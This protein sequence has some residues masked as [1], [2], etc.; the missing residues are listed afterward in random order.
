M[1]KILPQIIDSCRICPYLSELPP[2]DENNE[3]DYNYFKCKQTKEII[4]ITNINSI[5]ENCPLEDFKEVS[6]EK[7]TMV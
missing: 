2:D 3:D 1:K 5:N 7:N 6:D 4:Y